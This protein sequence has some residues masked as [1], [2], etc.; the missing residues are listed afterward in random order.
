MEDGESQTLHE[1]LSPHQTKFRSHLF[2]KIIQ[3]C[4]SVPGFSFVE[5][6]WWHGIYI[7]GRG[8]NIK[9]RFNTWWVLIN[10]VSSHIICIHYF[11]LANSTLSFLAAVDYKPTRTV[12]L[13]GRGCDVYLGYTKNLFWMVLI[14]Y[15]G[16]GLREREWLYTGPSE[17]HPLNWVSESRQSIHLFHFAGNFGG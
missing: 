2:P 6:A 16:E 13:W 14:H 17:S 7:F 10:T 1:S 11:C 12:L 9:Q 4:G 15:R 5:T 3:S 8:V